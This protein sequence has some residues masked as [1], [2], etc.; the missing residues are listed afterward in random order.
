MHQRKY[1]I[2][3]TATTAEGLEVKVV[4]GEKSWKA[5]DYYNGEGQDDFED[6][7]TMVKNSQGQWVKYRMVTTAHMAD[8]MCENEEL[9]Y[10]L[11]MKS[12]HEGGLMHLKQIVNTVFGSGLDSERHR[13]WVDRFLAA[14]RRD[15]LKTLKA[16]E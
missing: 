12:T 6:H 1:P 14:M 15:T 16:S 4:A 3:Y 2:G 7:L 13:M 9:K 8:I 10:P 5:A 11:W